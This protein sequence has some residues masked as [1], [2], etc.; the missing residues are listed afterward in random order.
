MDGRVQ[1]D[2]LS[3]ALKTSQARLVNLV[4]HVCIIASRT[5]RC[6]RYA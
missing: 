3:H 2:R 5:T 1:A 6:P 4:V